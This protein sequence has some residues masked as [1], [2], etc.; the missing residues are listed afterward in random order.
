MEKLPSKLSSL[1]SE[2]SNS[3]VQSKMKLF[4]CK[5]LKEII[6]PEGVKG[7][8]ESAFKECSA[9]RGFTISSS[10]T[11][12]GKDCFYYCSSL[13]SIMIPDS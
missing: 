8:R 5:D 2:I 10:I 11:R 13:E 12:I 4:F 3:L 7:N 9:L 6:I 1:R